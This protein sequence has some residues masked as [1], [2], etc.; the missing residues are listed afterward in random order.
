ME[1]IGRF[2]AEQLSS[3]STGTVPISL[4]TSWLGERRMVSSVS[5]AQHLG[6]DVVAGR[7]LEEYHIKSRL[8]ASCFAVLMVAAC[9]I[10]SR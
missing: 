2:G 8:S 1:R 3:C 7:G 5:C 9:S 6:R 10:S 4:V